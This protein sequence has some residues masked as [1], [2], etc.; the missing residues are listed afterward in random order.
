MM[1]LKYKVITSKKQYKDYCNILEQLV[2]SGAKDRNAKD[3]I[4]LLTLLIEKWDAE[5][6]VSHETDPI[7]LLQSFIDDHQLKAK[8]L[9]EILGISKG[10]VSD[11]LNYK[12]GLSKDVIRKLASYFKVSQEAFNRPYK[13]KTEQGQRKGATASGAQV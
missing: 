11:I 8:D 13:L 6:L 5:H 3:E 4:A 12:K 9:V 2:F 10:Y 7:Q 1:E